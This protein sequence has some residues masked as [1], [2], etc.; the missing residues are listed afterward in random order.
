MYVI[1]EDLQ[2]F[3]PK[4]I[5]IAVTEEYHKELLTGFFQDALRR[6][7]VG[8]LED[9]CRQILKGLN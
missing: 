5:V 2:E 6:G 4:K 7:L 1:V 8:D 3:V 9:L